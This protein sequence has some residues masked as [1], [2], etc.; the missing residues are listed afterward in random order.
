MVIRGGS[1]PLVDDQFKALAHVE[2]RRLLVALL[3]DDPQSDVPSKIDESE[4]DAEISRRR[5]AMRHDHLPRLDDHGFVE[6]DR[7]NSLVAK[8]SKFEQIEP[9]LLALDEHRDGLPGNL[10]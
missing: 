10:S 6:W 3:R 5:I 4:D 9:F 7:K 8:G 1:R 2:R